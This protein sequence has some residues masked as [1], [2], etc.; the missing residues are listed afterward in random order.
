ME[1]NQAEISVRS[2]GVGGEGMVRAGEGRG[3]GGGGRGSVGTL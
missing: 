3:H 2:G 1:R